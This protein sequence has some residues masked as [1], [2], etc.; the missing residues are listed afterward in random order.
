MTLEQRIANLEAT[1]Y[2]ASTDGSGATLSARVA[3]LENATGYVLLEDFPRGRRSTSSAFLDTCRCCCFFSL[4][5]L[6]TLASFVLV[7]GAMIY[8]DNAS[9][10]ES[11]LKQCQC[12][13]AGT[14]DYLLRKLDEANFS[15]DHNCTWID[16]QETTGVLGSEYR[17]RNC[18]HYTQYWTVVEGLAS[19]PEY[20]YP[21]LKNLR[22]VAVAVPKQHT[23]PATGWPWVLYYMFMNPDGSVQGWPGLSTA[24]GSSPG[25]LIDPRLSSLLFLDTLFDVNGRLQLQQMLRG[26]VNNG[27]ALVMI[28]IYGD[29]N[30]FYNSMPCNHL[31]PESGCWNHG[32]SPDANFLRVLFDEIYH[33]TL[34]PDIELDYNRMGLVGYS[35]G[36]QMVS[37]SINNFPTL[38][39]TSGVPFPAIQA[40]IMIGGASY[41]CYNYGDFYTDYDD[42]PDNFMPCNNYLA[43]CC[44]HNQ[45]EA[46]F[47]DGE[48]PW[49]DHPPA[50]IMQTENDSDADKYASVYY[51]NI[52]SSNTD[53][54]PVCRVIG[55]GTRHGVTQGQIDP[56]VKFISMH[57]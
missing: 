56:G 54:V 10:I 3:R 41:F 51:Y 49:D 39:T 4:V 42:I 8:E 50:L 46:V 5:L 43:G 7:P 38:V 32:D 27:Y 52:M 23:R 22:A 30:M 47:D 40:A 36:A 25:G 11:T 55:S 37:R 29:D 53:K 45:T 31:V 35:V 28:S 18:S 26:F 1:L 24:F 6:G 20:L 34:I 13:I 19:T 48:I 57:V 15:V 17:T 44:P 14:C 33:N 21:A 16:L 12:S 2:G 9:D